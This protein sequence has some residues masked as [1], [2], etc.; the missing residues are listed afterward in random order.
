MIPIYRIL[1]P[2]F[3]TLKLVLCSSFLKVVLSLIF[4]T[5]FSVSIFIMPCHIETRLVR[6]NVFLT[7]LNMSY[8]FTLLDSGIVVMIFSSQCCYQYSARICEHQYHY[9][10]FLWGSGSGKFCLVLLL[11]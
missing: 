3:S 8:F 4:Y 11:F 10:S 5:R 6:S 7:K 9:P 1:R 2:T